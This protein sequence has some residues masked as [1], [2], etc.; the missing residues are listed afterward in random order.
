M[1]LYDET[2][3][4]YNEMDESGIGLG[5]ALL[6]TRNNTSCPEDKAPGNNILRPI[7]FTSKSLTGDERR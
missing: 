2:K 6:Q 1:K 5:A 7:A 4:L 3:L